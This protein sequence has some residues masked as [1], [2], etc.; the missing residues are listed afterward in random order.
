MNASKLEV[1]E[2]IRQQT[3]FYLHLAEVGKDADQRDYAMCYD[4]I[5]GAGFC[6][7]ISLEQGIQELIRAVAHIHLSNPYSNVGT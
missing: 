4:K 5:R 3:P 1:A 7:S 2:L 6:T